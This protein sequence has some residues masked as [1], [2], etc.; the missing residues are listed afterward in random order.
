M[1]DRR[2]EEEELVLEAVARLRAGIVALV[3]GLTGGVL[4]FVATIGRV[5]QGG[6]EVG[7]HL[8]LLRNYFPGYTVTWPGA[9]LGFLYGAITGGAGGGSVAWIYTRVALARRLRRNARD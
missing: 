9:L 8:G 6:P 5:I 1:T 7:P 3:F 4:V 2:C